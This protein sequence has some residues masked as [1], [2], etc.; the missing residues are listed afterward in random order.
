MPLSDSAAG[1][2]ALDNG[3]WRRVVGGTLFHKKWN[4]V[5]LKSASD[6]ESPS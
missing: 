1:A 2:F 3:E 6:V 4:V 5:P